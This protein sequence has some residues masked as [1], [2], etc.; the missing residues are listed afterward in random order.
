MTAVVLDTGCILGAADT[1]DKWHGH[2]VALMDEYA[3]RFVVPTLVVAEATYMLR[4]RLSARIE[5]SFLSEITSGAL[6]LLTPEPA[7]WQRIREL[8][9]TYPTLGT[10]DASVVTAA[11]RHGL[12][13]IATIDRRDFTVVRPRH[14]VAFTLLP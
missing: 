14:V 5:L 4:R 7:D 2:C 13:T 8:V 3:G 11:E 10:V 6:R 9:A 12:T 1:G